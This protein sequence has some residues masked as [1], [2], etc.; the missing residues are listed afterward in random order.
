MNEELQN[1]GNK[2]SPDDENS[3]T[4]TWAALVVV[5]V[6]VALTTWYVANG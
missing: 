4:D 1:Q 2:A 5:L 3:R 6:L